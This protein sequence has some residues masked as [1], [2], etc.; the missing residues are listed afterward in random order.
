MWILRAVLGMLL[1]AVPLYLLWLFKA[2]LWRKAMVSFL[3]MTVLSVAAGML[4]A[5]ALWVNNLLFT[6]FGTLLMAVVAALSVKKRARLKGLKHL[7]PI[8]VGL[9]LAVVVLG[10]Y[11]LLL[12]SPWL[13]PLDA[14]CFL[15]LMG[16]MLGYM[17]ES[18]GRALDAYYS[19]LHHHGRLYECLL[20]NGATRDEAL[21]YFVRRALQQSALQWMG[22]TSGHVL[23]LSPV[24][25]WVMLLDGASVSDAVTGQLLLMVLLFA[26][27]VVS[28]VA[29]IYAARRYS[30][31][32]YAQI[33]TTR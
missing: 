20:A 23:C 6:L 24:I 32:D 33:K 1:L 9:F 3:R 13:E 12:V 4:V 14:T 16:L 30:F 19:G 8:V 7:V 29:T 15:P 25:L 10:L 17:A 26:A 5:V 28:V 22:R 2:D 31:D 11:W 27:S 18:D 21:K